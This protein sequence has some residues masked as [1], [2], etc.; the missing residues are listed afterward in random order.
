MLSCTVT[1]LQTGIFT[2]NGYD[3]HNVLIASKDIKIAPSSYTTPFYQNSKS[4]IMYLIKWS[5]VE[6]ILLSRICE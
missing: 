2:F 6:Y 5:M 4:Q 3:E 1:P